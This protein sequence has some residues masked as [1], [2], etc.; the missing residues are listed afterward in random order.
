[1]EQGILDFN[2]S[3]KRSVNFNIKATLGRGKYNL[4][5]FT[6]AAD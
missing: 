4:L 6:F 5:L 1:M 3:G 2:I